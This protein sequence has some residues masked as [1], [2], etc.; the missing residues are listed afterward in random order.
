MGGHSVFVRAWKG[1]KSR[2][3][4]PR[5][6]RS[7]RKTFDTHYMSREEINEI[8]LTYTRFYQQF[9]QRLYQRIYREKYQFRTSQSEDYWAWYSASNG[10]DLVI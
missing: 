3:P 1:L 9:Y 4:F 8:L 5:S 2:M 6:R 10:N 7:K